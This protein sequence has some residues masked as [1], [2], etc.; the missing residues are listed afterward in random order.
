MQL[1]ASLAEKKISELGF[2][3]LPRF[4]AVEIHCFVVGR[5]FAIQIV[6]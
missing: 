4:K 6:S 3:D 1:N 2:K 5:D